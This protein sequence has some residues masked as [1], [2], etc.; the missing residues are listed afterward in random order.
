V[1]EGTEA[2]G[3]HKWRL[4]LGLCVF[5]G[6]CLEVCPSRAI[7]A[8]EEFEMASKRRGDLIAVHTVREARNA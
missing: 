4:D 5:C 7:T 2:A 1:V 8:T 6:R 3:E